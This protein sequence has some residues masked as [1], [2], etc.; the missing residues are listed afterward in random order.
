MRRISEEAVS[1]RGGLPPSL[2]L[3]PFLQNSFIQV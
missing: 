3:E 1:A 2:R